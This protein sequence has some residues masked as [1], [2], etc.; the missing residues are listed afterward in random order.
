MTRR[1]LDL[2]CGAGGGAVG[3]YRAGFDEVVGVDLRYQPEYPFEVVEGDAVE[4]AW[5]LVRGGDVAGYR[6]DEFDAVH[7]SPPCQT[8]SAILRFEAR[9]PRLFDVHRD[10]IPETRAVLDATGLPY[11]IENVP[12]APLRAD[13]VL[14]GTM[15]GLGAET[16]TGF[17][18]L[19]RH[20]LFELGGWSPPA[21]PPCRHDGRSITVAGHGGGVNGKAHFGTKD[22]RRE[23]MGIGWIT[24]R[25]DLSEAIPP[26]YTEWIGNRLLPR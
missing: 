14:C 2:F 10:L 3:Y 20:R 15:F 13:L 6:L 16:R 21:P 1:L 9:R 5:R 22:E 25:E 19:R 23:A 17:R 11:V 26:A 18:Q 7:A 8:H 24:R 4:L 12:G